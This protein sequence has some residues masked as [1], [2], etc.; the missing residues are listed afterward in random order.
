MHLLPSTPTWPA[1]CCAGVFVLATAG[2]VRAQ[3]A[4]GWQRADSPD[5]G[6]TGD[7][8]PPVR[9]R[10]GTHHLLELHAGVPLSKGGGPEG[11]SGAVR[12]GT[13]G[14]LSGTPLR[15][16]FM[17]GVGAERRGGVHAVQGAQGEAAH[18]LWFGPGVRMYL[19][20][21][22]PLRPFA[23]ASVDA[24]YTRD[25]VVGLAR[26]PR[27]SGWSAQLGLGAGLQYRF[28]DGLSLGARMHYRLLS[29]RGRAAQL[30]DR[31]GWTATGSATWHF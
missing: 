27:V 2:G 1:L 23:E 28:F 15:F 16:Y 7:V 11:Q 9:R 17:A 24:L 26:S 18:A 8:P 5:A 20:V 30:V 31:Q 22:G 3:A 10:S 12:F 13:G 4:G 6:A 21:L 25:P 19:A 14:K 29:E